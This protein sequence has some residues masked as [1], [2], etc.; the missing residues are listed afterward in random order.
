MS[1]EDNIKYLRN[2]GYTHLKGVGGMRIPLDGCRD[3]RLYSVVKSVQAR[4][5][6]AK[7]EADA[8]KALELSDPKKVIKETQLMFDFS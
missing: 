6:K 2:M 3:A 1:R 5:R 7:A 8:A 4:K